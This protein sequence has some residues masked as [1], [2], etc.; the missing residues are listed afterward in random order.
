[1][2][3]FCERCCSKNIVEVHGHYQCAECG[4]YV[5][6]CYQGETCDGSDGREL[7]ENIR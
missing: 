7:K 3:D 1:M 2:I 4:L 5:S 6:E